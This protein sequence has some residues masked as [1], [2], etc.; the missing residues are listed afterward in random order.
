[1]FRNSRYFD[2]NDGKHN[3]FGE[4]ESPVQ[5]NKSRRIQQLN[6]ETKTAKEEPEKDE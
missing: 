3:H 5:N 4:W 2:K 1:M 6:E